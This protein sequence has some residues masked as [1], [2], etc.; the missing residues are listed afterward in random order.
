MATILPAGPRK[1]V[2]ERRRVH[3][4]PA[5]RR[6]PMKEYYDKLFDNQREFGKD[7]VE[8]FRDFQVANV[9]AVAPTQSGKTGT[10]VAVVHDMIKDKHL[11][12]RKEHVFIFT[13]HSSV[14]WL[15]QTRERFPAW[16]RE[17]IFHRCHWHKLADA[18]KQKEN[19]LIIID[20]CHVAS[21][22]N[23]TIDK[24][25]QRTGLHD[26]RSLY[27]R[28]I[29]LVQFTA[30]PENLEDVFKSKWGSAQR[31][32]TMRVPDNYLSVEKL[33]AQN[34]VL[35]AKNIADDK[36][37]LQH[38]KEIAPFLN[39]DKPAY[40]IV[41]TPRGELHRTVIRN[42]HHVFGN[43]AEL[44]STVA[45][46]N[47]AFDDLLNTKPR[48]H[49][50]LFIKDKLRCAKTIQHTYTGIFYDR[51]TVKYNHTANTQGLMG[52]NTGFHNNHNTT[53]FTN[54]TDNFQRSIQN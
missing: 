47:K 45:W 43:D 54:G 36:D 29:K 14:E 2:P 6:N 32:R 11:R 41:R 22:Q 9:L 52:R 15:D 10:M 33:F 16:M 13:G 30:T 7:I 51:K 39:D 34:R 49:T 35:K 37:A 23:Q 42:F 53:V 28:N 5:Y 3:R 26:A 48:K 8:E 38:V 27:A 40:H 4:I 17:Q 46:T 18:M 24:L 31:T 20:E 12:V 19:L 50:F 21:K 25:F 1:K 44:I